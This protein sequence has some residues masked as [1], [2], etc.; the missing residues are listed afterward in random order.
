M[1]GRTAFILAAMLSLAVSTRA[2]EPSIETIV[3][4]HIDAL[5]GIEKIHAIHSFIKH[6]WYREESSL[7]DDTF[8]AQMRPFYRVIGDPRA[9]GLKDDYE[10]YDGSA[11]EYYADPGLVVRTIGAAA[12]ATR[13]SAAFDDAL[14]DYERYGTLLAYEGS[15]T[16]GGNDTYVVHATL[17]DGFQE[18]LFV[19]KRTALIDGMQRIVPMHAFGQN[20]KETYTFGNY[21]P[22]GGVMMAHMDREVDSETGKVL[23]ESGVH[24]VEI[25]PTLPI[26]M[27]SPPE[28]SRTPV[29]QMIQL[30]YDERD[31][32]AAAV[33]TYQDFRH[34]GAAD[35]SLGDAGAVDFVGYQC[36]KMGHVDTALAI[37]RLNVADYPQFARAH[38]GLGRALSVNG[39]KK[40]AAAQFR[41]ALA[42]DPTYTRAK[43]A[44]EALA[45]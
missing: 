24:S 42:L 37:L 13:H 45:P 22:E 27:F 21:R 30:I 9:S 31:E 43:D 28:W 20:Y 14:V 25:N 4:A 7:D 17:Y 6:G 18:E 15:Q 29:Q 23:T 40:E 19:D 38:F 44:L 1:I 8:I 41:A 5:G 33:A 39:D 11:W 36:L 34:A 2:A 16:F 3:R 12:R 35:P 10:G 26:S 32:P